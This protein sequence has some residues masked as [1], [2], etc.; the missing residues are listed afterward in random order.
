MSSASSLFAKVS[1]RP[2]FQCKKSEKDVIIAYIILSDSDCQSVLKYY[3]LYSKTCLKRPL[4][5]DRVN[6]LKTNGILMKVE[7]NAEY[8]LGAFCN[9]FDLH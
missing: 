7:S 6:A 9:T 1:F 8:S 4:K 3:T 5:I 2:G